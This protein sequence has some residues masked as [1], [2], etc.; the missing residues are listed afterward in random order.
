[1]SMK[2]NSN[3]VGAFVLLFLLTISN[4]TFAQKDIPLIDSYDLLLRGVAL[5]DTGNYDKAGELFEQISRN[6]TNYSLAVYEDAIARVSGGEDS[7]AIGLCRKGIALNTEYSPDFYK[8][9]GSA[10][11]DMDRNDDAIK[12]LKDT[13]IRTFPNVY[14]LHYSLGLA[15][16]KSHKYDSA[17]ASFERAINLNIFHA[18]SHY[19]LGRCCLEQ[20]R[21]IPALLSLQ[22]FLMLEPETSRS[23]STVQLIEQ[24]VEGKY[25][26]NKATM[27]DPSKY[28]DDAFSDLDQIIKSKIALSDEYKSKTK[29]AFNIVKQCQ[30]FM[31]KLAYTPNTN[32]FWMEEYVPLFTELQQKKYFES[33]AYLIMGS[34][35]NDALQNDIKKNKKKI[36]QFTDW[37][38]KTIGDKRDKREVTVN[39]VKK[40]MTYFFYDNHMPEGFGEENEK[41]KTVGDWVMYNQY[42]GNISAKGAFNDKGNRDGL[43]VYYYYDGTMKEK[44]NFSDDKH[45]GLS[46]TWY[47]NGAQKGKY[48]YHNDKLNGETWEYNTSGIL[49][50]H[51]NYVNDKPM[52]PYTI[53]YDDGKQQYAANY[54][55]IGLDGDMKEY[56]VSGQISLSTTFK[57]GKKNGTLTDYWSN[58]KIKDRGEY[59]DD[60]PTGDWKFNYE[61]GSLHKEGP[62]TDDGKFTG[63]W[64]IYYRSGKKEEELNYNKVGELNGMDIMYDDDGIKYGELEYKN[65]ELQHIRYFDKSG[66]TIYESAIA[67]GKLSQQNFYPN[68]AKLSEGENMNGKRT[69][70]WLFYSECGTLTEEENYKDGL[71]DG[72]K[73]GYYNDGKVHDSLN[74]NNDLAEG[75][76]HE[77]AENG[78]L[79]TLGWY[80]DNTKQGDWYYY[81]AHGTLVSHIYYLNDATHGYADYYDVNGRLTSEEYTNTDYRYFDKAWRY[82]TNGT[83]VMY[84]YIS[85]KGNGAYKFTYPNGQVKLERNYIFGDVDGHQKAYYYDGKLKSEADY[86]MDNRQGKMTE[87]YENGKIESVFNYDLGEVNGPAYRFFS[88]GKKMTEENF[89]GDNEDSVYREYYEN[90]RLG[91]EIQYNDGEKNGVTKFYSEDSLLYCAIWYH[92]GTIAGYSY[93]GKDGKLVATIPVDKGTGTV[94][95]YYANGTKALE[96]NYVNGFVKGKR[97]VY[98]SAGKVYEDENYES[99][100]QSGIQKYYYNSGKLKSVEN[101]YLGEKDSTFSYYYETGKIEHVEHWVLGKQHGVFKYYDKQGK[102]LKTS[103]YYDDEV[104]SEKLENGNGKK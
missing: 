33:Y 91:R 23:F 43:W 39:G 3:I 24:V 83:K 7:L 74:Y 5:I 49:T 56:Y 85:D 87:Y 45:E 19:Y 1:M 29:L 47:G 9:L 76:Y 51:G 52:G 65:D 21:M 88:S 50:S 84:A 70:K 34:V 44:T 8:F 57:N 92:N 96:C 60:N 80:V 4:Y 67:N 6:D 63:L 12:M 95:C 78:K 31:E 62:Y 13:A 35:N 17:I 98:T 37:A 25:D 64:T 58:G 2:N 27:V 77:Y 81:D 10:Y 71:L 48:N 69:G 30:L 86:L 101:Y 26:Y 15:Y 22:F 93:P 89:L 14:L 36:T 94:I 55:D 46:E 11:I 16:Y 72:F 79:K 20:G 32:N 66:K 40:T 53:Y 100:N 99:G 103:V 38:G 68:G 97:M 28:N 82:D 41:G 104:I 75:L 61:N 18:S 42:T 59:K 102:L 73:I 54:S 90:G